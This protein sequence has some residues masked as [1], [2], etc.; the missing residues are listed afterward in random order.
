MAYIVATKLR[1]ALQGAKADWPG[2]MLSPYDYSKE[3]IFD[4]VTRSLMEKIDFK[5]DASYDPLYPDGIP[6]SII[7]EDKDGARAQPCVS[8]P[9]CP[10]APPAT[11]RHAHALHRRALPGPPPLS[12]LL[13]GKT[14]DSGLVMYPAGHARNTTT[15]LRGILAHKFSLLGGEPQ[16]C[17]PRGRETYPHHVVEFSWFAACHLMWMRSARRALAG[18]AAKGKADDLVK[19]FS[20][21]QQKSAA[22]VAQMNNFTIAE[23]TDFN[24]AS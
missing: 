2:L 18:L 8:P 24:D 3:A 15:D 20:N 13:S 10:C 6:T 22:E 23:R 17:A 21:L 1:K 5:H 7:I 9:P 12:S 16:L 11:P 4:P 14:F 19:R